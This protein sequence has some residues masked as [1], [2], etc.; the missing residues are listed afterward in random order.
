MT[1][2]SCF[3][4]EIKF[5]FRNSDMISIK[6]LYILL[7]QDRP[8]INHEIYF[9]SKNKCFEVPKVQGFFSCF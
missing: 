8:S 3:L 2:N 5:K 9:F 1:H 4:E 6:F 7:A